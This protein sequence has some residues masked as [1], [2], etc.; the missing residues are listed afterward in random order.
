MLR[1]RIS[2]I[3]LLALSSRG[4]NDASMNR[5][6]LGSAKSQQIR[7][8]SSCSSALVGVKVHRTSSQSESR[9]NQSRCAH[10]AVDAAGAT[11]PAADR[12]LIEAPEAE[13]ACSANASQRRVRW[14]QS[15]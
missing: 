3:S 12:A 14:L 9:R 11:A 15:A 6:P 10:A 5:R 8:G 2:A 4:A 7:A 13:A 1:A